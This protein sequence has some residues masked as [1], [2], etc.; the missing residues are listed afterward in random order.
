MKLFSTSNFKIPITLAIIIKEVKLNIKK[1]FFFAIDARNDV[2]TDFSGF[3]I[4]ISFS[5]E[6]IFNKDGK[7]IKS[8]Y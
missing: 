6:K 7:R 5:D 4:F 3:L 8:Y 1:L 2:I